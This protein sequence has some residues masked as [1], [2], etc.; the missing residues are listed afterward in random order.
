MTPEAEE[1]VAALI[2]M[3]GSKPDNPEMEP[4][5]RLPFGPDRSPSRPAG[6]PGREQE[7][8]SDRQEGTGPSGTEK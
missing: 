5:S 4:A 3:E 2:R 1:I 6:K 7:R 8:R